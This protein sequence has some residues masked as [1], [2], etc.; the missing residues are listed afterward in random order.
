MDFSI[1]A[2]KFVWNIY[3][4]IYS[5]FYL[6][7]Y[8]FIYLFLQHRNFC[9]YT[10]FRKHFVFMLSNLQ[11]I[12]LNNDTKS[13]PLP[14]CL[15]DILMNCIGFFSPCLDV[16]K[17]LMSTDSLLERLGSEI[18]YLVNAFFWPVLLNNFKFVINRHILSLDSS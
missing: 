7:I 6:L 5:F 17:I 16:P 3:L 8:L 1:F 11:C 12:R 14:Y 10:Y 9:K 13:V 2:K 15:F 18:L 4:F